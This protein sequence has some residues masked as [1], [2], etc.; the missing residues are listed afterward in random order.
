MLN[1]IILVSE[2]FQHVRI[3]IILATD[4]TLNGHVVHS[5]FVCSS[6]NWLKPMKMTRHFC[7]W[8][9]RQVGF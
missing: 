2:E 3:K 5:V 1:T 4:F 6:Q 7:N 9:I 8:N